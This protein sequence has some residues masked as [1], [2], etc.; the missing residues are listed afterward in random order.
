MFRILSLRRG[1]RVVH[2]V[3]GKVRSVYGPG[4]HWLWTWSGVHE[5]QRLKVDPSAALAPLS[6]DDRLD[7][8][9]LDATELTVAAGERVV[10]SLDGAVIGCVGPGR[11]RWWN[12]L[13]VPEL[14]R[15]D[16]RAR[17]EPIPHDDALSQP[18]QG[19]FTVASFTGGAVWSVGN[20]PQ[21]WVP[22]G[23][24]RIWAGAPW[25]L[26]EV[27]RDLVPVGSDPLDP[28]P[29]GSRVEQL[30]ADERMAV[31]L[32]GVFVRCVG[33]GGR[34]VRWDAAGTFDL[35]RFRLADEPVALESG[36]V[37]PP[38]AGATEV[39]G[40]SL[41]AA[42]L[43]RDGLP[44][45]V[46]PEGRY[47]TWPGS[48][49][50]LK[51]VPLS[52]QSLDVAPQD[53]LTHDQIGVR[54]KAAVSVRVADPVAVLSQ[55]DWP[56]QVY[57]AVQLAMREVV[58]ARELEPLLVD[59]G[60]A[61]EELVTLA[62][63]GLPDVGIEIV[64]AS[65]RD[66]ILPGEVKDLLNR[67]TLARKEAEALSIKRRE[68]TA[69]TRQLANTARLLENNPVLMRLKELEALGELAARIERITLVGSG[70]L[71][72]SVLLS[73]LTQRDPITPDGS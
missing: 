67:V 68:E 64:T 4:K 2:H 22:P 58:T 17:P 46:L 3:D 42:V 19:A 50:G 47:R 1:E 26:V 33:P 25:T 18:I 7:P 13:G 57:T 37:L 69:S 73:N 5:F 23:Q 31:F 48:R 60:P 66:V 32:D 20:T 63:A 45:R 27:P 65:I 44:V 39:A 9:Q 72:K 56:N 21:G 35:R 28:A 29:P 40:S 53:L 62:R 52:L 43:L 54:L 41:Q 8:S 16:L 24:Y 34:F 71:V 51:A 59:R 14:R 49:W 30:R 15:F 55:P 70:D 61:A 10:L 11:Y 6:A 38:G 36:D 12:E